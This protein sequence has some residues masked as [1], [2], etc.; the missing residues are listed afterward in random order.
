MRALVA[1]SSKEMQHFNLKFQIIEWKK[2]K[3]IKVEF[4]IQKRKKEKGKLMFKP[5]VLAS[6]KK[7]FSSMV[8]DTFFDKRR[9]QSF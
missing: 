6:E 9:S 1:V 4:I 5:P 8:N 2:G 3:L 7:I